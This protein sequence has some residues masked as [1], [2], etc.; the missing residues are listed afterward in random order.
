M[1]VHGSLS[2]YPSVLYAPFS[3]FEIRMVVA[4]AVVQMRPFML[5]QRQ[6]SIAVKSFISHYYEA[7]FVVVLPVAAAIVVLAFER[8][9]YDAATGT[10]RAALPPSFIFM[11]LLSS[12]NCLSTTT[13]KFFFFL[14]SESTVAT[15]IL[16]LDVLWAG[17]FLRLLLS[18]FSGDTTSD[19]L[20]TLAHEAANIA[21]RAENTTIRIT[22]PPRLSL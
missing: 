10:L 11:Q 5:E 20:P 17:S 1:A 4:Q 2:S 12:E 19:I 18:T 13:I 14:A 3:L 6:Y 21:T 9:V 15:L 22:F 8:S 16:Y 7:Q